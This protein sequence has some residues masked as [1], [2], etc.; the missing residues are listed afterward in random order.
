MRTLH[1]MLMGPVPLLGWRAQC[2]TEENVIVGHS[3][4]PSLVRLRRVSRGSSQTG[5]G[6][7]G[8]WRSAQG[9][10]LDPGAVPFHCLSEEISW[11]GEL[12]GQCG[13]RHTRGSGGQVLGSSC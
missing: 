1:V 10:A 2:S 5:L 7:L 8:L 4:G 11:K 3:R 9:R 12:Q 13:R 6:G